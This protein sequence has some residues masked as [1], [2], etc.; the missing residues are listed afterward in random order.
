VRGELQP[1]DVLLVIDDYDDIDW[2]LLDFEKP[3]KPVVVKIAT[4][5]QAGIDRMATQMHEH[6]RN[7]NLLAAPKTC[8]K[9]GRP[10]GKGGHFHVKHCKGVPDARQA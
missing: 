3:K 10:L 5:S 4:G 7:H 8:L 2:V 9:C 1:G 6:V